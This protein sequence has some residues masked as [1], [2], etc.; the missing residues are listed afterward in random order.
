[1]VL[2]D[3][4]K[5][6][7]LRA[8]FHHPAVQASFPPYHNSPGQFV[9]RHHLSKVLTPSCSSV[10]PLTYHRVN[11][12]QT[13]QSQNRTGTDDGA[14]SASA[15]TVLDTSGSS[16]RPPSIKLVGLSPGGGE[17][18]VTPDARTSGT[19]F[20]LLGLPPSP[21]PR[22]GVTGASAW[23]Q[24]AVEGLWGAGGVIA[25]QVWCK[26]LCYVLLCGQVG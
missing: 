6:P 23:G 24:T 26:G 19:A 16:P 12:Y 18:P 17:G 15:V 14:V 4:F 1:M 13:M 25:G 21:A 11:S 10:P 2:Y 8:S 22:S 5:G 20:N 3:P 7:P 9:I